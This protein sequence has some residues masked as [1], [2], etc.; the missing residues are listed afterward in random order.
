MDNLPDIYAA[1]MPDVFGYGI[2]CFSF[3]SESDAKFKVKDAYKKMFLQQNGQLPDVDF[4][5]RWEYYG[6]TTF[7][8]NINQVYDEN[9]H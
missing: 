7:Q 4:N 5:A 3:L 1:R 9:L 6:G 8:I 2:T